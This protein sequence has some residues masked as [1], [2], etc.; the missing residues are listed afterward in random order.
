MAKKQ[1]KKI[2]SRDLSDLGGL[3]YSTNPDFEPD[4]SPDSD[5]EQSTN[6]SQMTLYVSRDK[7]G[8]GGKVATLVEGFEG[9]D[10]ALTDLC[11]MLKQ[12][13]G[14]GGAAKDGEIIIQGDKREKVAELLRADG[15]KVKL[16]G[17]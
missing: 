1:P 8:R 6:P 3:V 11:K 12:K 16:K 2:K 7:K 14:V 5:D 9:S 17:G 15:Y 10:E 13:C 4:L